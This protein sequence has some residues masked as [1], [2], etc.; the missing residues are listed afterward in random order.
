QHVHIRLAALSARDSGET[1]RCV[2]DLADMLDERCRRPPLAARDGEPG[3]VR[4]A[5]EAAFLPKLEPYPLGDAPEL[6][7][8]DL[9][10]ERQFPIKFVLAGIRHGLTYLN[11]IAVHGMYVTT[12]STM[13][14]TPIN[15]Q[16]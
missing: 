7:V 8:A 13:N 1:G 15:H 9:G 5:R 12:N 16:L 11:Q 10:E 3:C 2:G 14:I 4:K 6:G